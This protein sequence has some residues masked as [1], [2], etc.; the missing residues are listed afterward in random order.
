M[1]IEKVG[2]L[3]PHLHNN[4]LGYEVTKQ[5]ND[6]KT[7]HPH[8]DSIVFTEEDCPQTIM[9]KFAIMNVSEAYDQ[10]GLMIATTPSTAAKLIYC[11]GADKKVFYN[12][13][14][15]WLRGQRT[16]YEYLMNLYLNNEFDL[17]VRSESHKLLLENNF[18][19]KVKT[20]VENFNIKEMLELYS[21]EE[22][23]NV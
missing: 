22:A 21:T 20:V 13:D 1:Q 11:W 7:T 18:T 17:I 2:I 15:Y 19:A 9:A 23:L 5:L 6:L 14:C 12:Y 3:L 4:Q 8:I 16:N 10:K